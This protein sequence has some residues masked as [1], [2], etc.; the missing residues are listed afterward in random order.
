MAAAYASIA[1]LRLREVVSVHRALEFSWD[2]PRGLYAVQVFDEAALQR[3][4]NDPALRDLPQMAALR[5]GQ[6]RARVWPAR[7]G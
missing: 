7:W 6:R 5:S 1:V 2:S 3:L 4:R